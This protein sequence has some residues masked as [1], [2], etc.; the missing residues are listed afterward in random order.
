M[1]AAAGNGAQTVGKGQQRHELRE[2]REIRMKVLVL[3]GGGQIARA[4]CAMA[5]DP[6][7]IVLKTRAQL[8]IG[9][10]AG[11][12]RALKEVHPSWVINGAAYTSVDLAEGQPEQAI[13][14]ND[15]AVG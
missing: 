9:D 11:V 14:A 15:T 2:N 12:A 5:P 1:A 3:G 8:D 10:A 13:E 7:A 4:V 6:S